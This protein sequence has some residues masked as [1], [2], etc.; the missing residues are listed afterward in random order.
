MSVNIEKRTCKL[1]KLEFDLSTSFHKDKNG[2]SGYAGICKD[3]ANAKTR[4]RQR[5]ATPSKSSPK[6]DRLKL[7]TT[8]DRYAFA[9]EQ[10]AM[11]MYLD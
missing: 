6:M 5:K 7:I 8:E 11:N 9:R 3:C 2:K 10:A 1:C 4:K